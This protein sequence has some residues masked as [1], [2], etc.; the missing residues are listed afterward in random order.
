MVQPPRVPPESLQTEQIQIVSLR[1]VVTVFDVDFVHPVAAGVV[2]RLPLLHGDALPVVQRLPHLHPFQGELPLLVVLVGRIVQLIQLG[3]IGEVGGVQLDGPGRGIV[4]GRNIV[5]DV[6]I[7]IVDAG[8]SPLLPVAVLPGIHVG[9][10]PGEGAL[11][12][13]LTGGGGGDVSSGS[14][15]L[16]GRRLLCLDLA[17]GVGGVIFRRLLGGRHGGS[18]GTVSSSGG[19]D[20]AVSP[21]P[22]SGDSQAS[23]APLDLDP[24]AVLD[25]PVLLL[26]RLFADPIGFVA[27]LR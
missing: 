17:G 21:S 25:G 27:F 1:L 13:M 15:L 2:G 8:M 10:E 9:I 11:G 3:V 12:V 16:G 23:R 14:L 5:R 7:N 24:A 22:S 4:G 19:G 6:M 26:L 18:G 20:A